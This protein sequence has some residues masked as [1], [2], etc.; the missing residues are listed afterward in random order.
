MAKHKR[1]RPG[2]PVRR[3][4]RLHGAEFVTIFG[5]V[6]VRGTLCHGNDCTKFLGVVRC[7]DGDAT[8]LMRLVWTD[9]GAIRVESSIIAN[10]I[11]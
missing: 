4:G 6:L 7:I 8:Q 10:I 1:F 2:G 9:A 11:A 5:A 3:S